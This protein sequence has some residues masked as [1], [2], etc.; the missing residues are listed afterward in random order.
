MPTPGG[1]Q[2]AQGVRKILNL[3]IQHFLVWGYAN[4]NTFRWF[5]QP[6]VGSSKCFDIPAKL[7]Y[8]EVFRCSGIRCCVLFRK[9]SLLIYIF[10]NFV[11]SVCQSVR[12]KTGEKIIFQF[13]CQKG[14]K[15]M[16]FVRDTNYQLLYIPSI[17]HF[18]LLFCIFVIV[19]PTICV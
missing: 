1:T 11:V 18:F 3:L 10:S 12:K 15:I 2:E 4:T 19:H 7:H 9:L 5:V 6:L 17:F 14:Q 13:R 8:D 16:T